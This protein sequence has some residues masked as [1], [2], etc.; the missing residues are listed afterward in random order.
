[1]LREILD[2]FIFKK[3]KK[4][5]EHYEL[6]DKCC[7]I[8]LDEISIQPNLFYHKAKDKII[9]F[10]DIGNGSKRKND[11]ASKILVVMLRSINSNWKQPIGYFC[12]DSFTGEELRDIVTSA[13]ENLLNIDMLPKAIITDQGLQKLG[14]ILGVTTENPVLF[15][16]QYQMVYMYMTHLIYLNPQEIVS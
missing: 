7:L 5:T 16:K 3:I 11:F 9:G 10:H 12:G 2:E 1:M 14:K 6:Q 13:V 15:V 4:V 8:L